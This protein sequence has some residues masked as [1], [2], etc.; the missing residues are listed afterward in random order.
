MDEQTALL[1]L[2]ADFAGW[3]NWEML[4]I[5][6][7]HYMGD[8]GSIGIYTLLASAG[9]NVNDQPEPNQAGQHGLQ[10]VLTKFGKE[11]LAKY[12]AQIS[13]G[14]R[15]YQMSEQKL[16]LPAGSFLNSLSG[17]RGLW[18]PWRNG[19]YPSGD[20][21]ARKQQIEQVLA[22]IKS[23]SGSPFAWAMLDTILNRGYQHE[24]ARYGLIDA[25]QHYEKDADLAY[26]VK[27]EI[28]RL[29]LNTDQAQARKL[30][31]ELYQQTFKAGALPVFDGS[32]RQALVNESVEEGLSNGYFELI[33]QTAGQLLKN[34]HYGGVIGLAWQVQQQGDAF[35]A[36]ELLQRVLG[37]VPAAQRLPATLAVIE[38][39][40]HASQFGRADALLGPILDD[41]KTRDNPT[42]WRLAAAL[43]QR[44]QKLMRAI[45]C[46]E[47]ALEIEYRQLPE[48][49][50]LQTVRRDFSTLLNAYG[51]VAHMYGTL[52][53]PAPPE[54][55]AQVIRTADR[56]RTLDPDGTHACQSAAVV[57][58]AAG[59]KEL[60]WDY[61]TTPIS[62]R[63]NEGATYHSLA[64]NLQGQNEMDLADKA[65]VLAFESEPTNAQLL[66]DRAQMLQ[67]AGR[68]ADARKVYQRLA[69][70][71][72]Q[73]R[74]GWMQ[75]Q[76][77]WH[78]GQQA[79]R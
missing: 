39:Y 18:M 35:L 43:A 61:L 3:N 21:A 33:R 16:D 50:N 7:Q 57:L 34:K 10:S 60:A 32:L 45:A 23:N 52:E 12:L 66:W 76:A 48:V 36:D 40:W 29:T 69:D 11:P 59:K 15:R 19:N 56:W 2:A 54:F 47:K 1:L 24:A 77:R 25:L 63:P 70:G 64:Q 49:I 71:Q 14:N 46:L 13:N 4:N 27:Y 79:W 65:Y 31:T 53:T 41:P 26:Y 44:Q 72:W 9:M 17:F 30:Y 55:T 28:A 38:N 22:F 62:L 8:M 20:E 78:L 75:Q 51:A 67:H 42:L 37:E 68:Y 74:F 6:H 5:F 73:S 58:R